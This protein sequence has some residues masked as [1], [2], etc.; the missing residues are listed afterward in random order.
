[1]K[2][3]FGDIIGRKWLGSI[4]VHLVTIVIVLNLRTLTNNYNS[5]CS[6][7]KSQMIIIYRYLCY[8]RL[9][10]LPLLAMSYDYDPSVCI[11]FFD[12]G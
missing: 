6:I 1:M 3:E 10:Y 11:T 8:S 12:L 4:F 9:V 2:I 5:P 7:I